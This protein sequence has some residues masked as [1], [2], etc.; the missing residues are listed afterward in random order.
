[1][2]IKDI[3][4]LGPNR[5]I[6]FERVGKT[7]KFNKIDLFLQP[8]AL[9]ILQIIDSKTVLSKTI[10]IPKGVREITRLHA[11]LEFCKQTAA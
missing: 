11:K 9:L 6:I 1:M 7:K 4:D 10:Q 5:N 8:M 3:S 2:E